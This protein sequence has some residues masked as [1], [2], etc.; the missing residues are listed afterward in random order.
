MQRYTMVAV[1][2]MSARATTQR[3]VPTIQ[4]LAKKNSKRRGTFSLPHLVKPVALNVLSVLIVDDSKAYT[5][6][7]KSM[8]KKAISELKMNSSI[9]ILSTTNV[10]SALHVLS[11]YRFSLV[12]VDNIFSNSTMTGIELCHR[13]HARNTLKIKMSPLVVMSGQ[14]T[15]TVVDTNIHEKHFQN[16]IKR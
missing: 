8:L 10:F 11:N 3:S 9:K 16:V 13:L 1:P 14:K 2:D 12:L 6:K 7:L 5:L 4:K 15:T